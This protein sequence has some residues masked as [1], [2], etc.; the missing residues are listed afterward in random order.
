MRFTRN[1]H[2]LDSLVLLVLLT[3]SLCRNLVSVSSPT[4]R[5]QFEFD[6]DGHR[7]ASTDQLQESIA[8]APFWRFTT[9]QFQ[10]LQLDTLPG[11]SRRLSPKWNLS[12]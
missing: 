5:D 1:N 2:N 10:D 9:D 8:V 4:G 3:T 12:D 7:S 6:R 11:E